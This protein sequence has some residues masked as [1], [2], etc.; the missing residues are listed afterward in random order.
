MRQLSINFRFLQRTFAN[1]N[2]VTFVKQNFPT[3]TSFR[4][5]TKDYP[6][7]RTKRR[8]A[9]FFHLSRFNFLH[10]RIIARKG[11][12]CWSLTYICTMLFGPVPVS[13]DRSRNGSRSFGHRNAMYTRVAY[14]FLYM[15]KYPYGF[16]SIW[17]II[18]LDGVDEKNPAINWILAVIT[19]W[20]NNLGGA[21][22][23][24]EKQGER[25]RWL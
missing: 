25:T 8:S 17:K 14:V 21:T 7:A 11:P 5:L 16:D 23:N 19:G 9:C 10:V 24:K 1:N 3:K 15:P 6:A 22:A 13:A 20:I 18:G 12:K 4:L 2:D